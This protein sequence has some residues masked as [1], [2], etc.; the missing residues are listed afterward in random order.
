MQ[1]P[2]LLEVTEPC[3]ERAAVDPQAFGRCGSV[4]PGV[5]QA[6]SPDGRFIVSGSNQTIRVWK[7]K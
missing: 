6:I 2:C 5:A 7:L 1:R 4:P 3:A